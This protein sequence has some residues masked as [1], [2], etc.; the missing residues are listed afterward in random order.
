MKT[1][2]AFDRAE[3]ATVLAALRYYQQNGQGEPANR[4]DAIHDIA[5]GMAEGMQECVSLDDAAIDTLCE[6][7]NVEG[8][9]TGMLEA[10]RWIADHGD[11]GECRRP[12]YH[13]M[14][15]KARATIAKVEGAKIEE[16]SSPQNPFRE[17]LTDAAGVISSLEDQVSQ[18]RGMFNDED[19]TIQAAMDEADAFWPRYDHLKKT[20]ELLPV[21]DDD[22]ASEPV[23]EELDPDRLREDRDERARLA[24][25]FKEA[26]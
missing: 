18:M 9:T 15:A 19:G 21:E 10:L 5:T 24:S 20:G 11:T 26:E 16:A 23:E 7:I 22:E 14:R 3:L 4:S 2:I 13:D 6:R 17:L 25:E 1:I 12:A 8:D